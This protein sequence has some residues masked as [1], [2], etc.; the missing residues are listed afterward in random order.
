MSVGGRILI[1][2]SY[3]GDDDDV[4]GVHGS[5]NLRH[6]RKEEERKSFFPETTH[7]PLAWPLRCDGA[8]CAGSSS[9]KA[10]PSYG[11]MLAS[12]RRE[13]ENVLD[14]FHA[15]CVCRHEHAR[16]YVLQGAYD[17]T[18]LK[19]HTMPYGGRLSKGRPLVCECVCVCSIYQTS[20]CKVRQ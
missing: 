17:T 12:L 10:N 5:S 20:N 4:V 18:E 19:L 16:V 13:R 15:F 2:A 9:S 1:S 14:S 7:R 6:G 8:G 11:S 3:Q